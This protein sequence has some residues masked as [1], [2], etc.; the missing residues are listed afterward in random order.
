MASAV[1]PIQAILSA[2]GEFEIAP[3]CGCGKY[4]ACE[5]ETG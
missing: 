5:Q 2:G 1:N 3:G 4:T